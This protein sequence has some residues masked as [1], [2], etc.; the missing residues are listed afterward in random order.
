MNGVMNEVNATAE[1]MLSAAIQAARAAEADS[2]GA[3]DEL[4]A[5]IYL[6][7][8]DGH[9]TYY[10]PA[11]VDLAGRRPTVGQD[12]W[13]VTWKIYTDDGEFLPHDQCPMAV[14]IKE[15]RPVR[16][17]TAVAER[18]DGSR[19]NFLP[20]PTP[21][22]DDEGNLVGGVNLLLD[23]TRQKRTQQLWEQVD[24]CRRLA[25]ATTDQHVADVLTEMASE[26]EEQALGDG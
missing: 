4:P 12:S 14:A 21:I 8:R 20:F 11:C 17:V 19:V 16:G 24:R 18:P 26:Y 13:C 1:G 10:N 3:L 9:L 22:L 7:D 5:A 23:I 25:R 15:K 6:T 2:L